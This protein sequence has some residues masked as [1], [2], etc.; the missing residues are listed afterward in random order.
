LRAG[1]P[2]ISEMIE[3]GTHSWA[4]IPDSMAPSRERSSRLRLK[5][6]VAKFSTNTTEQLF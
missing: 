3:D 6:A 5:N 4:F 2:D 1:R